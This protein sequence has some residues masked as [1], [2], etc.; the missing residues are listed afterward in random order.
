[1]V[2]M[3]SPCHADGIDVEDAV[4]QF[5]ST[6]TAATFQLDM[7]KCAYGYSTFVM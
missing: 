7:E 4:E 1:M 6:I 5:Q 3:S 2:G